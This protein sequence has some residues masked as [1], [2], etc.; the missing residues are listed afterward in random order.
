MTTTAGSMRSSALGRR[1]ELP[2]VAAAEAGDADGH[3][4]ERAAAVDADVEDGVF[5]ARGVHHRRD[6][7]AGVGVAE[8][9]RPLR[10]RR[11][12]PRAAHPELPV[13][14]DADPALPPGTRARS[15]SY[16]AC[17]CAKPSV[18]S[19]QRLPRTRPPVPSRPIAID[20]PP[21][22]SVR[23]SVQAWG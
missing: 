17:T 3:V 18:P 20:R 6:E 13:A 14:R 2:T 7:V 19:T 16:A 12:R 15:P 21:S 10:S 5:G 11:R 22:T 8:Q 4:D 23:A 1:E 9:R